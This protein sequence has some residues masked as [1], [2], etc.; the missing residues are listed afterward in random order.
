MDN[1]QY[2]NIKMTQYITRFTRFK[3][4]FSQ[5]TGITDNKMIQEHWDLFADNFCGCDNCADEDEDSQIELEIPT[6]NLESSNADEDWDD[7][8]PTWV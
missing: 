8:T 1:E 6:I 4:M 7:D 2:W 3:K 5:T